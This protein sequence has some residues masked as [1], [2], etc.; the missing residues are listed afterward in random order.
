MEEKMVMLLRDEL[1]V[2]DTTENENFQND[3]NY[4]K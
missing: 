1:P 3:Y 4:Q 2:D